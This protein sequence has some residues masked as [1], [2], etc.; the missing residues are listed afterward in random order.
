M[1]MRPDEYVDIKKIVKVYKIE[2]DEE[3]GTYKHA[4]VVEIA[5]AGKRIFKRDMIL[6]P[7][8][9]TTAPE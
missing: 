3:S 9:N 8:N 7:I 2:K 6:V 1:F 5:R 4:G